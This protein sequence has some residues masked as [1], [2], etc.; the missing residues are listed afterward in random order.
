MSE[1]INIYIISYFFDDTLPDVIDSIRKYTEH[2]IRIIVGDNYSKNSSVIREQISNMCKNDLIDAAYFYEDN[3]GTKIIPHMFKMEHEKYGVPTSE[4]TIV[5][6]GDALLSDKTS[7]CWLT[8]FLEKFNT[9]PRLGIVGFQTKND[10][11][12]DSIYNLKNSSSRF[13][14][15]PDFDFKK[16]LPHEI[17]EVICPPC[18]GHL[19]TIKTDILTKYFNKFHQGIYDGDLQR[20]CASLGYQVYQYYRTYTYNLGTIKGGYDTDDLSK[21]YKFEQEYLNN[22]IIKWHDLPSPINYLRI[23]NNI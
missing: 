15:N 22:R 19:L 7:K 4:Y 11:L 20:Y 16:F 1:K 21:K 8:D 2:P 23:K 6:D 3:H 17:L 10:S 9:N 14:E 12:P 13:I 5:S 18:R